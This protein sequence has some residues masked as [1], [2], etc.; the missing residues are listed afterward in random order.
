MEFTTYPCEVAPATVEI[1]CFRGA[2]GVAEYHLLVRPG[3]YGSVPVQLEW[4]DQAYQSALAACGLDQRS[5][6]QRRFFCSDLANQ[7]SVLAQHRLARRD[8]PDAP[9]AVSWVEQP[10]TAPAKVALWA[11]H[12]HDPTSVPDKRLD[13][14]TLTWHR[15]GHA[16]CWTTGLAA[17][18]AQGCHAQMRATLAAYDAL[19]RER[20]L[21]LAQHLVRTW[22]FIR[23]IDA[24]YEDVVAA[25]RDCFAAHGLTPE[26]H[27]VAST[28]IAGGS[29]DPRALVALDAYAVGGLQPAQVLYLT[30]PTHLCP[31]HVY[32]VTFERGV[33]IG[34]R[35]RRHVLVSG[36]ASIDPQGRLLHG[37]D[38]SRQ[39]DR[40][41]EN[42]GAL[43]REAGAGWSDLGM[44]VAYVRDPV[45][46]PHVLA[47]L[48]ERCGAVPVEVVTAAICRPGWLVEVEC[49]AVTSQ[50]R[51]DLPAF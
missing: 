30:A 17:P 48:R 50:S 43:L 12:L 45:D 31:T 14:G 11:Y 36:T 5:A 38:V 24:H 4:L 46:Q 2:S 9:C 13:D 42:V 51:P 32:G 15:G 18:T 47:A 10:P 29:A 35:D 7:A 21:S 20:G 1:A 39:L 28:G 27:F 8:A 37:G 49:L 34:Y 3:R 41:L 26:T 6:A 33:A 44:L 19:L 22:L 25:R 23:D 40:T 16:H